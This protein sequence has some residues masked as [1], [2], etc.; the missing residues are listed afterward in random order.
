MRYAIAIMLVLA[1]GSPVLAQ[2]SASY[3]L[4]ESVFNAGGD[5]LQGSVLASASHRVKLDS[6]GEG[7]VAGGLTSASFHADGSFASTYAPA[8]EIQ[9]LVFTN[10]QTIQWHPERSIGQYELYRDP[11]S[12]LSGG[13]TGAC[14]AAGLLAETAT[15]ATTPSAGSGLF[16][17]ATARNRLG[18]EGTKGFKTTGERPNL[19]P[20]P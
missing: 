5:P 14:L 18:E 15:D 9:Q 8:G 3:K 17:L 4:Q 13:G 6:L 1:G 10:K 11:L 7:I 16:Y 2:S 12:A 19:T 20:C